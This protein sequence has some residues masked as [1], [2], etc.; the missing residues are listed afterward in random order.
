[1]PFTG[2]IIWPNSLSPVN[3]TDFPLEQQAVPNVLR[4]KE[5]AKNEWTPQRHI[6][7]LMGRPGRIS[8]HCAMDVLDRF[9]SWFSPLYA[10]SSFYL[11]RSHWNIQVH[12]WFTVSVCTLVRSHSFLCLNGSFSL[13][14]AFGRPHNLLIANLGYISLDSL[15]NL[16]HKDW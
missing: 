16:H 1:M 12:R 8:Y 14:L 10:Q 7:L 13:L 9:P 5:S 4:L 6:A 11:A 15:Y 3:L 2:R